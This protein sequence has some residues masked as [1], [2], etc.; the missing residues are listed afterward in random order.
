MKEKS[1]HFPRRQCLLVACGEPVSR[2]SEQSAFETPACHVPEMLRMHK[3][4]LPF[5][6]SNRTVLF[7]QGEA[8]G[9]SPSR[10]VLRLPLPS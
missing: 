7:V 4:L 9:G 5:L 8:P 3:C 10:T 1:A 6:Q 2:T